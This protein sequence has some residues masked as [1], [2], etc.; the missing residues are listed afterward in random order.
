MPD[1]EEL[2]RRFTDRFH[3]GKRIRPATEAQIGAAEVALGV[4]YPESYRRFALTCGAL[5]T[6]K[7]L[8]IIAARDPGFSDVQEFLTPHQSVT[9]TRRSG[10]DPEAGSLVLAVD[11]S[12]NLFFF[13]GLSGSPPR[14]DDSPIWLFD[15][16]E[17]ETAVE[18]PSFDAWIARFLEL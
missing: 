9:E 14:P 11:C 17:D 2:Y 16:E 4:L 13:R 7:L 8:Q 15:H 10:F 3:A 18:A 5:S 12:G 6:G 1:R